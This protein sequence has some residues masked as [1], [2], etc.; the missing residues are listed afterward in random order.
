MSFVQNSAEQYS[1]WQKYRTVSIH[2]LN[3]CNNWSTGRTSLIILGDQITPLETTPPADN[4]PSENTP[5]GNPP[6]APTRGPDHNRPTWRGIIWKLALT[7]IAACESELA[8]LDMAINFSK[9]CCIR[10]WNCLGLQTFELSLY[11]KS[12]LTLNCRVF[13]LNAVVKKFVNK[14]SAWCSI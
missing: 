12:C 11:V 6:P 8:R 14:F 13:S 10:S 5:W 1:N 4:L 3:K 9:S 7:R 2:S